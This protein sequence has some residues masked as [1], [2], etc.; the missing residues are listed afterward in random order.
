MSGLLR[1]GWS[2]PKHILD[3]SSVNLSEKE[4][5]VYNTIQNDSGYNYDGGVMSSSQSNP[6]SSNHIPKLTK[7]AKQEL[8][9]KSNIF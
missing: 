8:R 3:N 6:Y 1:D 2:F 9:K 7:K 4:E 5:Y